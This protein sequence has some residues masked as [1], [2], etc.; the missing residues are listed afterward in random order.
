MVTLKRETSWGRPEELLIDTSLRASWKLRSMVETDGGRVDLSGV[1]GAAMGR[2]ACTRCDG[3]EFMGD[4]GSSYS[5]E[6]VFRAGLKYCGPPCAVGDTTGVSLEG[7]VTLEPPSDGLEGTR[8]LLF[9]GICKGG[10]DGSSSGAVTIAILPL[11]P[12]HSGLLPPDLFP[13]FN[14]RTRSLNDVC[15][16]GADCAALYESSRFVT[17]GVNCPGCTDGGRPCSLGSPE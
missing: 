14:F 2:L 11:D 16:L 15:T 9:L 3:R 12:F 13:S 7:D 6:V 10:A 8:L 4:E 1:A 5:S 17:T